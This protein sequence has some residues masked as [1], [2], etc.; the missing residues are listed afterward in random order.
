MNSA[1]VLLVSQHVAI[2]TL[3]MFSVFI[4]LNLS[5]SIHIVYHINDTKSSDNL[6]KLFTIGMRLSLN[7]AG[8]TETGSQQGRGPLHYE[9]LRDYQ[10]MPMHTPSMHIM[11]INKGNNSILKLLLC[12]CY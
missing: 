12:L 5:L 4:I 11:T 8:P 9:P 6:K 7:R 10:S 1:V 2:V 3:N